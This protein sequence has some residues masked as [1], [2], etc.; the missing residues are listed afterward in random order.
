MLAAVLLRLAGV[1]DE[2]IGWEYALT[3][4][5]LGSWRDLFIERISKAGMGGAS[6][7]EE[8]AKDKEQQQQ[9]SV[10][11]NGDT[12]TAH[13]PSTSSDAIKSLKPSMTRSEAARIVGARAGNMRA[14]LKLVMDNEFGGVEKY[15]TEKCGL[16]REDVQRLREI[17]V[18]EV[19]RVE[20]V[21]PVRA[22]RIG[23]W[24]AEG[25]VEE[26]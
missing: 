7:S 16:S 1:D 5:G 10:T 20:D 24:S 26:E 22:V 25:G 12:E 9:E 13:H 17:L 21:V 2:T 11:K 15:L 3:E 18:V 4:P 8:D 14:F 6:Q 23:G 19:E